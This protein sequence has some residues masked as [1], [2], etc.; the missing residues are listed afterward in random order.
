MCGTLDY[1]PPEM[2]EGEYHDE[3]VDLWSLGVLCY[4]CLAGKP[5]FETDSQNETYKRIINIDI[6]W[7]THF[8]K[9]ACDLISKLL[10]RKPNDRLPLL[11]VLE[12]PWIV[13]NSKPAAKSG[14]TKPQTSNNR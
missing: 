12:H 7:P 13:Q 4:E 14:S 11:N 2:I 8:S 5:P 3:K 6:R 10:R 9:G 1:L